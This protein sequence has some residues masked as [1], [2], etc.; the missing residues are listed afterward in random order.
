MQNEYDM[1]NGTIRIRRKGQY[2]KKEAAF[3]CK[4]KKPLT[5]FEETWQIIHN[6]EHVEPIV[7]EG[8]SKDKKVDEEDFDFIHRVI[9][10]NYEAL[11]AE[12]KRKSDIIKAFLSSLLEEDDEKA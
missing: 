5:P 2:T 1:K 4:S 8:I 7:D 6:Y 12:K 11:Q 10:P 9:I 3:W